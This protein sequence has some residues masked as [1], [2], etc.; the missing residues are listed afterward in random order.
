MKKTFLSLF[1]LAGALWLSA[2]PCT[3]VTP[4]RVICLNTI[5][6]DITGEPGNAEGV[7]FVQDI[8]IGATDDCGVD[9]LSL[10][11]D[12]YNPAVTDGW[13]VFTCDDEGLSIPV[14]P[15]ATDFTGKSDYCVTLVQIQDPMGLLC[16]AGTFINTSTQT[17]FP[18]AQSALLLAKDG[19]TISVDAEETL[20]NITTPDGITVKLTSSDGATLPITNLTL[21][22][23]G[24]L[25]T[26]GDYTFTMKDV[27]GSGDGT[28]EVANL[29]GATAENVVLEDINI[30]VFTQLTVSGAIEGGEPG[31]QVNLDAA[32][33]ALS[34]P[35][36]MTAPVGPLDMDNPEESPYTAVLFTGEAAPS[37]SLP[38]PGA[39]EEIFGP[40]AGSLSAR[41]PV[42]SPA[43]PSPDYVDNVWHFR[44]LNETGT[45]VESAY[46]LELNFPAV[47]E[48]GN[49]VMDVPVVAIQDNGL[50]HYILGTPHPGKLLTSAGEVYD[51]AYNTVSFTGM[52]TGGDFALFGCPSC[53][54]DKVLICSVPPGNPASAKTKCIDKV[55]LADR[56]ENGSYCG[57]CQEATAPG[58]VAR[59][60]DNLSNNSGLAVYPN[61]A[62]GRLYLT[63]DAETSRRIRLISMNGRTLREQAVGA[64]EQHAEINLEGLPPGLYLLQVQDEQ[65][66]HWLKA[67]VE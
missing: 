28:W 62:T 2:Q 63:F 51:P 55:S 53:G 40:A 47:L 44:F 24:V 59:P 7:L 48:T 17:P 13:V 18:S 57:P 29:G 66:G 35:V 9:Y 21:G 15:T 56:L 64:G 52:G 12:E 4:P 25:R 65:G 11:R 10:T 45:P 54:P 26:E 41:S 16:P 37:I 34:G 23:G 36:G 8:V 46:Q 31:S 42:Q 58:T 6:V 49:T 27:S 3:D 30:D 32:G 67:V 38:G 43:L 39:V 14:F 5:N 61:P 33:G 1:I 60:L 50:V 22:A 20:G 19:N